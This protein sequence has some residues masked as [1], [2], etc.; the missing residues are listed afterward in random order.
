MV[1]VSV[2]VQQCNGFRITNEM[3]IDGRFTVNDRMQDARAFLWQNFFQNELRLENYSGK[4]KSRTGVLVS[5]QMAG[6]TI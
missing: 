2:G 3:L 6:M 4:V 1:T 5:F